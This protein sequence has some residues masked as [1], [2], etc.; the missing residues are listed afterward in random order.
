MLALLIATIWALLQIQAQ[1]LWLVKVELYS[2]ATIEVFCTS[3]NCGGFIGSI[4]LIKNC[5]KTI[6]D[7]YSR[8]NS[9]INQK[10]TFL[11]FNF[12]VNLKS[13]LPPFTSCSEHKLASTRAKFQ[14]K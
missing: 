9:K 3:N 5:S 6:S 12:L 11:F 8:S 2:K 10:N 14:F 1:L 13:I 4:E 7:S